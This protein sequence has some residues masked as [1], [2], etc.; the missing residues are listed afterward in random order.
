MDMDAPRVLSIV[1]LTDRRI[2]Y[3]FLN[4]SDR[5]APSLASGTADVWLSRRKV[6]KSFVKWREL[7][8]SRLRPFALED[9]GLAAI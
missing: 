1:M 3:F 8:L 4:L 2:V 7:L 5:H 9:G 6:L